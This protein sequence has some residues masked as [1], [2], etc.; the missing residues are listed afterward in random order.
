M[1]VSPL[2]IVRDSS[3]GMKAIIGDS[4]DGPVDKKSVFIE[5]HFCGPGL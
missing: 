5:A 3:N 4:A 2:N 1:R